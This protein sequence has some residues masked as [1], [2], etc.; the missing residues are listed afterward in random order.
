METL[1]DRELAGVDTVPYRKRIRI[2][3]QTEPTER[4]LAR[5]RYSVQDDHV[6]NLDEVLAYV[7]ILEERVV[8]FRGLLL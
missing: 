6:V 5:L 2:A 8:A 4:V 1:T 7:D 3:S